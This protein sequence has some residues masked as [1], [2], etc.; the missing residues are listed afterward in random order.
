MQYGFLAADDLVDISG[1]SEEM[2]W[3]KQ[4]DSWQPE[5]EADQTYTAAELATL[6]DEEVRCG[7]SY[8]NA[9][10]KACF[11]ATATPDC[12]AALQACFWGCH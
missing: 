2:S 7:L 3:R 6:V 12:P 5:D 8:E 11:P 9:S 1:D 4:G 10:H